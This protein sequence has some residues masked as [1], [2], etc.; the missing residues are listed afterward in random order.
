MK[1]LYVLSLFVISVLICGCEANRTPGKETASVQ[2]QAD[3]PP[4]TIDTISDAVETLKDVVKTT[5]LVYSPHF[6]DGCEVYLK[7]ENSQNT[8]SFK[9][10]GAYY[11]ISKLNDEQKASG[12]VSCSAGNHAQGVAFAAK[13]FGIKATIFLP[14]SAPQ[15]KIDATRSYGVDVIIVDGVFD[16]A[17]AEALKFT[18]ETGAVYIPP[19][20][21]YDIIAGQGTIGWEILEQLPETDVI[22][23]AVGGGGLISG[24]AYT[25]KT[26]KPSCKV[27]GVQAAGAPGMVTSLKVA[28]TV[29]MGI[30]NTFA[31]GIAVKTPGKITFEMCRDYVDDFVVVTDKEIKEAIRELYKHEN[32]VAEGA[33]AAPLAAIMNHML[34]L[35]GKKVVCVI[36]GGN[37]DSDKL[38]EILQGKD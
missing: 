9:I 30:V 7:T 24:I 1:K 10:R 5:E 13:K 22:V 19:F 20:D 21:H 18:E 11:M 2:M 16:D 37:I 33:G 38:S 3:A 6:S 14:S 32:I 17:L 4:L 25:V 15:T 34:P 28:H 12:V 27:Y 36:S 8:G 31:D 29:T 35:E 26:L 23:V